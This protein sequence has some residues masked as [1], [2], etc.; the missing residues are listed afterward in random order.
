VAELGGDANLTQEAVGT[1]RLGKLRLEHLQRDLAPMLEI[2]GQEHD[3][4]P[5]SRSM[6]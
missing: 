1:E 2:L 5:P 3:R 4:H 6:R